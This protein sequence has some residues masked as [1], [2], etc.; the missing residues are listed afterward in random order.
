MAVVYLAKWDGGSVYLS[1]D[2]QME[3]YLN[4]GASIYREENGT[5]TLIA[6]P[7]RGF[8]EDRPTFPIAESSIPPA[9]SEYATAGRILL[10]LED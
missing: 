8:I 7:E 4:M 3:Q 9:A 5:E 2:T 1:R 10:G 6:T